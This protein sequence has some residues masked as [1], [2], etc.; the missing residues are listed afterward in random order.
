MAST[1]GAAADDEDYYAWLDECKL[2][3]KLNMLCKMGT[4][5]IQ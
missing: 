3:A 2:V 5:I 1:S 4:F